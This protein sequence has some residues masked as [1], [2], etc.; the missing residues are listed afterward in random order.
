[1][2]FTIFY[3]R[4]DAMSDTQQNNNRGQWSSKIGFIMAAAGSAIGL[5]NIWRFPYLT[6]EN[7]GA[8]FVFVYILC[9]VFIGIPVMWNELALGRYTQKN[10]IGA[11]IAVR[12]KT[13][14]V[15]IGI[16]SF[17]VCFLVLGYYSVIAG[18]TIGYIFTSLFKVQMNFASFTA[19]LAYMIPLYALFIFLTIWI[20][21]CG[22]EKGIERWTKILMP[23]LFFLCIVVCIRSV[24]L[25]NAMAGVRYY[26]VPDF[27]KI[28]PQVVLAAVGQAFFSLSVGWGLMIVYGS[29]MSK[30]QS[31]VS[32]GVSVA[33]A[34]T[35]V[36]L[37]GGFMVFPAVFAF[38]KSPAGGPTLT[39]EV[40]PQVF[41][42]MPGG[43]IVGAGFFLLLM[44]AAL[45]SSISMLEVPVSYYV[46][47]KK[48]SRKYA[49]WIVGIMAFIVGIPSALSC[50]ASQWLSSVEFVGQ[51]GFMNIMDQF[52][53]T[54]SLVLIA[55]LICLFTG[56][57][58]NIHDFV[59]EMAIGAPGFK[60][61]RLIFSL[62]QMWMFFTR[63]L[64]PTVLTVLLLSQIG[65]KIN[66]VH[67]AIVLFLL[68]AILHFVFPAKRKNQA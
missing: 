68:L 2:V 46:D 54:L 32:G 16:L 34:D 67:V 42:M 51:K 5:G 10:P 63:V 6:G 29:Y 23:I 55:L 24:T 30:Q 44:L 35:T 49:S 45:T 57:R 13:P 59:D 40:L 20:V 60:Q 17:I 56:W 14:W 66:P 8:A 33:V 25:P 37:L 19:N 43:S 15:I 12:G 18:W 27:A 64:C 39:F 3:Y 52:F 38:G 62:A 28:T 65:F 4:K 22:I 1:M 7:G 31:I 9:V 53:G 21:Q 61:K 48:W 50:G 47:E 26:L 58:C 11:I 36:A 41:E